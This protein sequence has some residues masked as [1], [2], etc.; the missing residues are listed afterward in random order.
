M[1][2]QELMLQMPT[3]EQLRTEFDAAIHDLNQLRPHQNLTTVD[4]W[5]PSGVRGEGLEWPAP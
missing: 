3:R 2:P 4:L 5:S 1:R